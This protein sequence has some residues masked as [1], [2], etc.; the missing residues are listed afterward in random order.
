MEKLMKHT[1]AL[2]VISDELRK[3]YQSAFSVPTCVLMTGKTITSSCANKAE[4][5]AVSLSYFGNVRCERYLSLRK[6]GELLDTLGRETGKQYKLY[7]Y[8][9]ENDKRVLESLSQPKSIVFH[10]FVQGEEFSKAFFSSELL[11]HVES[12]RDDTIDRVRHSISTKVADSL[13]SG[14]PLLAFGPAGLASIEHLRRNE[15]A[16]VCTDPDRL[17]D[18]LLKAMND[19]QARKEVVEHAIKTAEQFHNGKQN[20]KE[21]YALLSLVGGVS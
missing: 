14:I 2:V 11:V 13:A 5:P 6:I 1:S 17:R 18:V 7:V 12:F 10:D 19:L 9:K 3:V 20:S 15:C 4:K 21:L 8:S 16:F